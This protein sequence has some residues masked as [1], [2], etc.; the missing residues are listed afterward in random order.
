MIYP[1]YEKYISEDPAIFALYSHFR[2]LLDLHDEYIVIGYSFRDPSINNAFRDVLIN[3]PKSRIIIVNRDP[4]N[5]LERVKANFP[6]K[7]V[8]VI[9]EAFG[10]KNLYSKIKEVIDKPP[11]GLT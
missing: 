4:S 6:T 5:I 1:I 2:K 7:K 8:D 11:Q 10:N 3:R 9:E